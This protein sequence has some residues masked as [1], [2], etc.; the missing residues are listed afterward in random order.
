VLCEVLNDDGTVARLP[1]LIEFKQRF[2]LKMISIAQ[3]IEYRHQREQLVERTIQRP[4]ASDYGAFT[5]HVFRS[6]L[7][8]RQ[9]LALTLGEPGPEPTLVRVHSGNLLSEVFRQKDCDSQHSLHAALEQIAAAGQGAVIYMEPSAAM[10]AS[11]LQPPKPGSDAPPMS[12]RDYGLGAQILVALGL[13]KIRLLSGTPRR[14]VGLDGYGLEIV[15]Q[16]PL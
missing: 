5:L 6:R 14:V 9:H 3:L 4:F 10:R 7:D 15:E 8:G 1:Q 16:V 11:Q 13:R 12:F 2:G